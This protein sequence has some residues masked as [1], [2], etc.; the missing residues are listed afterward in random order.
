[1]SLDD[2]AAPSPYLRILKE[3]RTAVIMVDSRLNLVYANDFAEELT[4]YS[5]RMF[6]EGKIRWQQ[7][8][9]SE[10]RR[11]IEYYQRRRL[12]GDPEIPEQFECRIIDRNGL[13][14]N[15]LLQVGALGSDGLTVVSIFDVSHWKRYEERLLGNEEKLKA[16]VELSREITL[17]VNES[18]GIEYAGGAVLQLLRTGSDSLERQYLQELIHEDDVDRVAALYVSGIQELST[19][20]I[21]DFRLRG[22]EGEW[23]HVEANCN[24]QL[25]NPR[26]SGVILTI[27]DISARKLA[28][29]RAQF[30]QHY[31]YLT[32]LPNRRMFFERLSLE[33]RHIKRRSTTFAV[34]S[35]GLDRFKEINDLFGPKVGDRL[36]IEVGKTLSGAFRKDDSV[37]RL[38]GDKFA[39]LL[40]DINRTE[41]IVDIVKKALV[42]FADP[43]VITHEQIQL[44]ASIGVAVYPD[45]GVNEDQLIKNSE[46]A[47]FMAKEKGRATFQLYN[48][49]LHNSMQARRNLERR[50]EEALGKTEFFVLYQPK[51]DR[52]GRMTGAEALARWRS[53]TLGMVTPDQ[54]IPVAEGT[55]LIIKL[56]REIMELA[57]TQW[58]QMT[59]GVER[60]LSLAVN[61]SPFEFGHHALIADIQEVLS[62][63][64][65]D[66][67][68]LEIEI[69]ETGIMRNEDDAVQKLAQL[70]EMGISIAIDDFGT[71]YSSLKKLKDFPV[72]TVKIDK[73]FLE[74]LNY[75][76]KS[77]TIIN[78]IIGLAHDLEFSVVAE[79]VEY[80]EQ[81][82]FLQTAGCDIYQGYLFDKPLSEEELMERLKEVKYS[83]FLSSS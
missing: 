6:L 31:D 14:R 83:A 67:T 18:M 2:G 72:G 13:H 78:A 44:S 10:D 24:N 68:R 36:L 5:K 66:P 82:D 45:D 63:T 70:T 43:I 15:L 20:D 22:N 28:E 1:M 79:G 71:G 74:N 51:V 64:G 4:G 57:C 8:V 9:I 27:R 42:L 32:R 77:S 80:P 81:L 21:L 75:S 41:H 55:G 29:E 47:L 19:F 60:E 37:S 61:L 38:E 76:R 33:L 62:R 58:K 49:R 73:S 50:L 23:I 69:T 40:T 3:A 56:G 65:F 17:V 34:L 54:F 35:I 39:V 52:Q 7:L 53:P 46:T 11:Q 25:N 12:G 16:M 59:M 26:I 30:Y 48:R